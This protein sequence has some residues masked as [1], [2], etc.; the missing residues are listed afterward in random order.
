MWNRAK[1]FVFFESPVQIDLIN[2]FF[3]STHDHFKKEYP[4]WTFAS[5]RHKVIYQF[6]YQQVSLHFGILMLAAV[7]SVLF[8]TATHHIFIQSL[9]I[10]ATLSFLVIV[11]KI[12]WP[13]YF[14]DFLPKL[15][16]I[17]AEKEK[18]QLAALELNKCKRTQYSTPTLTII[19]YI[20]CKMAGVSTLPVNDDSAELLNHLYGVDK[21][22]LKQNMSRLCRISKLSVKEAAEMRKGIETAR[23][24]FT[25]LTQSASFPFL[26]QLELKISRV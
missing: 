6:W 18:I 2:G 23:D 24:Y 22:K 17:I 15:D 16:A 20:N 1:A 14:S 10:S 4:H 13:A 5:T 11:T 7:L 21:D 19:Y 12:Y 3:N 8:F 26:D 25:K 9:L